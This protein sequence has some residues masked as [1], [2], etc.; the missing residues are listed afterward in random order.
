M[1]DENNKNNKVRLRAEKKRLE[2]Q[3]RLQ[4]EARK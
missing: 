2:E 1:R 3:Q 4:E